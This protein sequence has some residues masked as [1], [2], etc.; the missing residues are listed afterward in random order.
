M[1]DKDLLTTESSFYKSENNTFVRK[2][3]SFIKI[4]HDFNIDASSLNQDLSSIEISKE[5]QA[6]KI[7]DFSKKSLKVSPNE[8][9][10][11][12]QTSE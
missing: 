8:H 3:D 1:E 5:Y 12:P 2:N 6:L 7:A 11:E 9:I 10:I 4:S